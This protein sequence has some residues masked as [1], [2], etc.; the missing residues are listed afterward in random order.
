MAIPSIVAND[1]NY[2]EAIKLAELVERGEQIFADRSNAEICARYNALFQQDDWSAVYAIHNGLL[3]VGALI[4]QHARTSEFVILSHYAEPIDDSSFFSH[5]TS[6]FTMGKQLSISTL[7]PSNWWPVQKQSQQTP[8]ICYAALPGEAVP[9]A[10]DA[11]VYQPWLTAWEALQTELDLF[12]KTLAG[13]TF[14]QPLVDELSQVMAAPHH[15]FRAAMGA[16]LRVRFGAEAGKKLELLLVQLAEP[17]A[18]EPTTS[19]TSTTS[20]TPSALQATSPIAISPEALQLEEDTPAEWR[21]PE[22]G[23]QLSIAGHGAGGPL[24]VLAALHTRRVWEARLDFPLI[25]LKLYTFGSPKVGN[26][27]FANYHNRLLQDVSFRVQNLLDAKTFGPPDET[28]FPYTP[29]NPLPI[30]L[31]AIDKLGSGWLSYEHVGEPFTHPG[32]GNAPAPFNFAEGIKPPLLPFSHDPAGYKALLRDAQQQAQFFS[33][34]INQIRQQFDEQKEQL[35]TQFQALATRA[36]SQVTT[37]LRNW[38]K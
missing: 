31:P 24:A 14:V 3:N 18:G 29:L 17:A 4:L 2:A 21:I 33:M 15:L 22:S 27:A 13:L 1:F 12:F 30:R 28:P 36:Q 38:S 8:A 7:S 16:A 6:T 34:P 10:T 9:P 20:T 11:K 37:L 23:L 26:H 32:I 35:S 5:I 25:Q 19:T